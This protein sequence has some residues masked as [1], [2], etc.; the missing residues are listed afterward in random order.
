MIEEDFNSTSVGINTDTHATLFEIRLHLE[1]QY[2]VI[3]PITGGLVSILS[4]SEW[5][6]TSDKQCHVLNCL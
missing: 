1:S 6:K 4:S 3:V 2:K 5:R